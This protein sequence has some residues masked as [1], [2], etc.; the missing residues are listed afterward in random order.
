MAADRWGRQIPTLNWKTLRV[1]EPPPR[2]GYLSPQEVDR[3]LAHATDHLKPGIVFAFYTGIRL[4]NCIGLNWNQVDLHRREVTIRQK[5]DRVH[6]VPLIEPLFVMLANLGQ[7]ERGP[8]FT[9]KPSPTAP[10]R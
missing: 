7:K 3:I 6:V 9:W 10:A 4:D 1:K 2:A 8:V 5:G